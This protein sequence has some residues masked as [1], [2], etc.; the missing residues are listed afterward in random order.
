[1]RRILY[2]LLGAVGFLLLIATANVANLLLA[3][4]AAREREIAVRG[5]LGAGCRRI[6]AQ[7]V[8]ESVVLAMVSGLAGL[9]LA[10][11]GTQALLAMA[12]KG[13]PRLDEAAH[14]RPGISLRARRGVGVRD[15][16]RPGAGAAGLAR[17]AR[18][19]AQGRA[20]AALGGRPPPRAAA[21]GRRRDRARDDAVGRCAA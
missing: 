2:A 17:A 3:R 20:G 15:R 10:W 11:W 13:I 7:L 18:R 16:L 9:V 1:M 5:A 4:A 12:P 21:A 14:E 6:V 8:T 19:D